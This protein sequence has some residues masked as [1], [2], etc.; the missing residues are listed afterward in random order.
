MPKEV[1]RHAKAVPAN[2]KRPEHDEP[3]LEVTWTPQGAKWPDG[4]PVE[5]GVNIFHLVDHRWA[6]VTFEQIPAPEGT[7]QFGGVGTW[8]LTRE[9]INRLIKTLRRARNAAFGADE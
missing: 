1:I 9:E 6:E 8:N 4:K 3:Q 7:T 2:G 5:P